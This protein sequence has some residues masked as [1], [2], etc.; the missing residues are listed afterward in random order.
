MAKKNK[1]VK[2]I[3]M[4]LA[5]LM[6]F[7]VF[8]FMG[9]MLVYVISPAENSEASRVS[10]VDEQ[11][12]AEPTVDE[13]V[14]SIPVEVKDYMSDADVGDA[15]VYG[16]YEQNGISDDGAEPIEWIVIDKY[17]EGILL[18]SR[19]C[20]DCKPYNDSRADVF[21]ED[22]SLSKWLNDGF[23]NTAFDQ[24][25][26]ANLIEISETGNKVTMLYTDDARDYYEYDSWRKTAATEYAVSQG[27]RVQDG[28]AMWWL[29][30][31]NP[32]STNSQ[33]VYYNGAIMEKGFAVDYNI[34]G[35]RP[36]I[37]VSAD[38]EREGDIS[39]SIS[40]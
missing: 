1:E 2:P 37:W 6:A 40:Q 21:W 34:L 30:D 14:Q 5:L 24:T 18:V 35:V 31:R 25:E 10:T 33:Y 3:S 12:F 38:A 13:P 4:P 8:A 7:A 23:L 17:D 9:L 27:V 28:S 39:E 22:S 20:L 29:I 26:Q 32:D 19:Y 36:V 11:S 15:V 16:S